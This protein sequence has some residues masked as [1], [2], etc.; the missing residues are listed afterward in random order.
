MTRK[1]CEKDVDTYPY[2][3]IH[4]SNCHKMQDM[5]EKPLILV[6]FLDCVTNCS[7]RQEMREKAVSKEPFMLKIIKICY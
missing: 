2:V 7:E 3:L 5:Y 6:C 4:A 1:M